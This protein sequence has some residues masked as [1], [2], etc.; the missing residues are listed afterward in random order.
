[1][2]ITDFKVLERILKPEKIYNLYHFKPVKGFSLDSRLITKGQAFVAIKGKHYDGHCFIKKAI[3]KG[4]SFV[5][6]ERYIDFKPKVP[7]LS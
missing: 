4:A 6:A 1:M 2:I 7:F 5:V 3:A